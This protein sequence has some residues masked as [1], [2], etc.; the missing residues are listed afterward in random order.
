MTQRYFE[1][2]NVDDELE[3]VERTPTL[4]MAKTLFPGE[5]RNLAFTDVNAANKIGVGGGQATLVPGHLKVSWLAQYVNAWAGPESFLSNIR[6]ALRRPDVT[7]KPLVLSGRVVDKRVED[8]KQ[9]VELEVVTLADGQPSV[10][11]SVQ[12]H[13]PSKG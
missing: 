8:G 4:E 10:R 13:M 3:P 1:D 2:V 7:D 6:V 12:V 9:I 5:F 11:A